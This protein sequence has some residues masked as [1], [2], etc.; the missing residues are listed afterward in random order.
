MYFGM[1]ATMPLIPNSAMQ[2]PNSTHMYTGVRKRHSIDLRNSDEAARI[3]ILL[4]FG[5]ETTFF[6]NQK[7]KIIHIGNPYTCYW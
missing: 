2:V 6:R 5:T 3:Y 1:K 7:R 4:N